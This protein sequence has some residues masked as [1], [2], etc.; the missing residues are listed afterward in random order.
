[1]YL[2]KKNRIISGSSFDVYFGKFKFYPYEGVGG[3]NP[4]FVNNFHSLD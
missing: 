4:T 3:L 1:M 2:D